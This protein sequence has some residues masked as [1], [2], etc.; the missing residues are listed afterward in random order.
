MF[1]LSSEYNT[2]RKGS[3]LGDMKAMALDSDFIESE[4]KKDIR[5][6]EEGLMLAVLED[7]IETFRMYAL[8]ENKRGK[9][10]FQ[11]AEEWILERDSDWFFSFEN[12]CEVLGL[13]P[14]YLRA[15]LMRWKEA[16]LKGRPEAKVH[17][18][19]SRRVKRSSIAVP[20]T[21]SL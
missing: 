15:G 1:R 7:A 10:L 9:K 3:T 5:E 6:G 4:F 20:A 2:E 13:E 16:R 11:E 12:I 21:R 17:P 18:L 14:N 19:A 8:A